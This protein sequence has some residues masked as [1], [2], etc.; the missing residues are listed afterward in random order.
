MQRLV[1]LTPT[2]AAIMPAIAAVLE[3]GTEEGRAMAREELQR[4]A[5]AL[6]AA[7]ADARAAEEAPEGHTVA[8][9]L[10]T[11]P[12][13]DAAWTYA[14]F[15]DHTGLAAAYFATREAHAAEVMRIGQ[16]MTENEARAY[17]QFHQE[18]R[19]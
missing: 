10:V 9:I 7:N 14:L 5:Q 17:F 1:D 18:Y 11:A 13:T 12:G 6:D 19:R 2:W 3:N 8:Q 15:I 16:K 4:A